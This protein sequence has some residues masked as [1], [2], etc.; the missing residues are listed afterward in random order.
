[1]ITSNTGSDV[2]KITFLSLFEDLRIAQ[3][4]TGHAHHI[5]TSFFKDLVGKDRVNN[6]VNRKDRRILNRF[7]NTGRKIF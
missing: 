2:I 1:M 4:S 5:G 7:F 3:M 6:G